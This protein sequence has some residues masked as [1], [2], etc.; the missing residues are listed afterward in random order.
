MPPFVDPMLA[1]SGPPPR[2]RGTWIAEPKLDG[3]R[4]QVS[5]DPE[6]G[7]QI[8]TRRGR[9]VSVPEMDGLVD[10]GVPFVLDGELVVEAGTA[11][12]FYAVGPTLARRAGRR[13]P[14][15][16]PRSTCSRSTGS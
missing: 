14:S 4:A 9:P 16:L 15:P 7:V 1:L 10:V 5:V 3:W 11:K 12:D 13:H 8:R 6:Q 2:T